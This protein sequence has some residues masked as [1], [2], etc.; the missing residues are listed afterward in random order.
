MSRIQQSLI[1]MMG[2]TLQI[3]RM[4]AGQ[5]QHIRLTLSCK[6]PCQWRPWMLKKDA[7]FGFKEGA[8]FKR[9]QIVEGWI[10]WGR[11]IFLLA[12]EWGWLAHN[13][14]ATILFTTVQNSS[15]S[16]KGIQTKG[17]KIGTPH[18]S[19]SRTFLVTKVN[20]CTC[21]VPAIIISAWLRVSPRA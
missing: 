12:I 6:R 7:G 20:P 13:P 18:P 14:T 10:A 17:F 5:P 19:K 1:T 9:L 4:Q 8:E 16:N 15:D 21:A 3:K 11:S 2:R